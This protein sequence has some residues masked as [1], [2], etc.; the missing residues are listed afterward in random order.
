M[1]SLLIRPPTAEHMQ[2]V[3]ISDG[4][5]MMKLYSETCHKHLRTVAQPRDANGVAPLVA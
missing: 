4:G 5:R 1:S 3:A 2:A